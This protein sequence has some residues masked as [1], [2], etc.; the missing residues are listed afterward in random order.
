[1]L[2]DLFPDSPL[3]TVVIGDEAE[4]LPDGFFADCTMMESVSLPDAIPTIGR[5]TFEGC[6]SLKAIA[7]PSSVTNIGENAFAGCESLSRVNVP[8][9]KDWLKIKFA[10]DA[11]NPLYYG[12]ELYVNGERCVN[13]IEFGGFVHSRG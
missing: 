6:S 12:A 7:I 10:N 9:V 13:R 5:E 1:M 8:S 11:A 3:V 2:K 4:T